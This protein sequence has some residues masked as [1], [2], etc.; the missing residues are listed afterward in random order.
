[1][2]ELPFR[3]CNSCLV[4]VEKEKLLEKERK[5]QEAEEA[6][7]A[8]EKLLKTPPSELFL[9]QTDKFSAFDAKVGFS[10]AHTTT[11]FVFREREPHI[12]NYQK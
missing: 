10:R 5:K 9:L 1:M 8:K 2:S 3:S 4:Q 11:L 6:R 12:R 7:L